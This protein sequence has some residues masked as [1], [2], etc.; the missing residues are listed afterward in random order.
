V[1]AHPVL[2]HRGGDV[3]AAGRDDD[4]LLAAGNGQEAL[5]VEIA[6]VTGGIPAVGGERL[7]GRLV[8]VPV[9]GKIDLPRT[10]TSPSSAIRTAT[11]GSG[12]PTVPIFCRSGR[13]TDTGALVSVSPYPSST[14]TPTPRKKCPSREASAAPPE[15]AAWP[16]RPGRPSLL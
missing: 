15:I 6:E 3:L 4:L 16:A 9:P 12:R 13:F 11:P 5:I 7:L 1:H 14:A 10:S 2:E 8:V